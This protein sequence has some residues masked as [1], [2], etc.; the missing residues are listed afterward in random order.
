[1]RW[2]AYSMAMLSPRPSATL[3]STKYVAT[4]N[5]LGSTL[6]EMPAGLTWVAVIDRCTSPDVA[7][8]LLQLWRMR[9]LPARRDPAHVGPTA[10]TTPTARR[11]TPPTSTPRAP[12]HWRRTP[13]TSGTSRPGCQTVAP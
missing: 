12:T 3:R 13:A 8:T 6:A 4:L 2:S 10:P 5:R 7:P 1:M 11:D 9:R